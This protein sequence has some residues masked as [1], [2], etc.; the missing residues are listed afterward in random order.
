MLHPP[1][2]A[3]PVV[4]DWNKTTPGCK[5][6]VSL[7][8]ASC[9]PASL[10]TPIDLLELAD[11]GHFTREPDLL[12]KPKICR[13]ASK[14]GPGEAPLSASM[15]AV[16]TAGRKLADGLR[17]AEPY[18]PAISLPGMPS[19]LIAGACRG[20]ADKLGECS[21]AGVMIAARRQ[22]PGFFQTTC[23]TDRG[24]DIFND[25]LPS[26]GSF[27]QLVALFQVR[28]NFRTRQMWPGCFPCASAMNVCFRAP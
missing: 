5:E 23:T 26:M 7:A 10:S 9:P 4:T 1:T 14:S 15:L 28:R 16:E 20:L 6:L 25:A 3:V 21:L 19:A 18:A 13:A 2:A 27:G 8:T 17:A 11:N 24:C 12:I 22:I